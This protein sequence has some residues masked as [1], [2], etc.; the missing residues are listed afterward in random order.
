MS[1]TRR[2][3]STLAG[4]VGRML[5]KPNRRASAPS[6]HPNAVLRP[7]GRG[8]ASSR[9]RRREDELSPGR[10][11]GSETIQVHPERMPDV[12]VGYSPSH[13]GR[14]DSGEVIWTWV[15]YEEDDGRG[16]DRPVLVIGRQ[17][18]DRVFA[19]RM[20]S[21]AHD[22]DRDFLSIGSGGWDSRG[23]E[24]WVDIEQLYSVHDEGMRREAAVLDRK[25]YDRVVQ[26]LIRRYG[27]ARG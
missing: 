1:S 18:G 4:I 8:T 12:T 2:I 26:A 25:R 13:N 5:T 6:P 9:G 16:K 14:P 22:R 7:D 11:A 17:S 24:S 15:P 27:W 21:K 10:L 23:R 20:T 19:V 3:L